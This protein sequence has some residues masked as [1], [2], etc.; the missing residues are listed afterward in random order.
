MTEPVERSFV[1]LGIAVLTISDTRTVETDRSGVL[2]ALRTREA[3]HA[4]VGHELV[5][6]DVLAIR[7]VLER[8][9]TTPEVD[10]VLTTGGTG[11]AERDIT[12]E[13]IAPFVTREIPGFGELFRMLSFAEIGTSTIQ[14]RAFAA[15]CGTTIVCALPGSPGACATAWD[16]I[17]EEQL[18]HR[19]RP[20]NFAQLLPRVAHVGRPVT[21]S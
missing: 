21:R 13:A 3:G 8:F 12:P 11:L 16:R 4:L 19:H 5:H 15:M 20:C 7:R 17:L 1:P 2:L 9:V 10:V 18:D 6:D 14:S